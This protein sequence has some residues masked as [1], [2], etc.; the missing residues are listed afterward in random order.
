MSKEVNQV[1]CMYVSV[2]PKG[3]E[4]KESIDSYSF[5]SRGSLMNEAN[6]SIIDPSLSCLLS[7]SFPLLFLIFSRDG[8]E[9]A[10]GLHKCKMKT[11]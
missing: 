11:V 4:R 6:F 7:F 9:R 5:P 3:R 1:V 2:T 10:L 8:K